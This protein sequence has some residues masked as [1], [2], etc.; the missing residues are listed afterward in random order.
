MIGGIL[1]S[2]A[3]IIAMLRQIRSS[4]AAIA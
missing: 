2:G 1:I 3:L 4:T